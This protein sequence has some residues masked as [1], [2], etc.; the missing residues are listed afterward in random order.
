M[1]LILSSLS[2]FLLITSTAFAD[3]EKGFA[4]AQEGD[5]E[6]AFNEYKSSA[7]SGEAE[8]QFLLS[9][10]YFDG[11]GTQF[12]SQEGLRWLRAAADQ[13]HHDAQFTLAM[14]YASGQY[15]PQND[16]DAF[17]WSLKS[18]ENGNLPGHFSVATFY[19]QGKGTAVNQPLGIDW[20]TK[21]AEQG[22]AA[23]QNALS[24][25]Y[26]NGIGVEADLNKSLDY[27][28]AAAAGGNELAIQKINEL[29]YT[30]NL[31]T[32]VPVNALI[33]KAEYADYSNDR[34]AAYAAYMEAAEMDNA[35]GQYQVGLYHLRG[36]GDVEQSY[37]EA[38]KW[39]TA[40]AEN[41]DRLAIHNLGIMHMLGHGREI[42]IIKATA[43]FLIADILDSGSE[44]EN[45]RALANTLSEE[46]IAAA[47]AEANKWFDANLR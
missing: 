22:L 29:G 9:N 10:M 23:S 28:K 30:V 6:T 32:S 13:N 25:I 44:A 8:A 18:A 4:A 38:F 42:D 47:E 36:R 31:D 41:G 45:L 19:M 14:L 7:E 43:W 27:L 1:K 33:E 3:I 16:I 11:L 40:A 35:I 39:F 12:S 5:F 17:N 2:L 34:A 24:I 20:H 21:A 46:Q 37:D 15:V 26:K